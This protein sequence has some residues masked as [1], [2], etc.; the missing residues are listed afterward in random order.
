MAPVNNRPLNS[1]SKHIVFSVSSCFQKIKKKPF[2]LRTWKRQLK[3]RVLLEQPLLTRIRCEKSERGRL[4]SPT[5]AKRSHIITYSPSTRQQSDITRF[6]TVRK[7]LQTLNTLNSALVGDLSFS[8]SVETLRKRFGLLVYCWK[9]ACDGRKV[10][11]KKQKYCSEANRVL[12]MPERIRGQ[13][14]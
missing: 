5:G 9:Y 12:C 3:P 2:G 8:G 6:Y 14:S 4:S 10:I 13:V 11:V 1:K 7:H